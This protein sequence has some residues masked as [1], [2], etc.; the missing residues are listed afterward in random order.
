MQQI[1]ISFFSGQQLFFLYGE[2]LS[3]SDFLHRYGFIDDTVGFD[4]VALEVPLVQK[5]CERVCG[6]LKCP[7]Y[8]EKNVVE[9]HFEIKI[10]SDS[11]SSSRPVVPS[12]MSA[13]IAK[14]LEEYCE[15][16]EAL[17]HDSM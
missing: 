13:L 6:R 15:I 10:R 9:T 12:S 14:H 1:K 2:N 11:S 4:K 16:Q 5:A 8:V 7:S 17:E 3:K